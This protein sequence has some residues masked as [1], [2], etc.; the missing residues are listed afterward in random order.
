MSP[1][2]GQRVVLSDRELLG[3][4]TLVADLSFQVCDG[5]RL[6]WVRNQAIAANDGPDLRLCCC[7]TELPRYAGMAIPVPLSWERRSA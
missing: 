1:S 4:V 7:A 3:E 5:E 2:I 6:L